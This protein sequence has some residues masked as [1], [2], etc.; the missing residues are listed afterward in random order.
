MQAVAFVC[1]LPL[2]WIGVQCSCILVCHSR[3]KVNFHCFFLTVYTLKQLE[4]QGIHLVENS[5]FITNSI[6]VFRVHTN[7]KSFKYS[8]LLMLFYTSTNTYLSLK[9]GKNYQ[10]TAETQLSF[11]EVI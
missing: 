5:V 10:R 7:N 2:I 6:S 1:Q 8:F 4:I 11:K 3:R 9:V